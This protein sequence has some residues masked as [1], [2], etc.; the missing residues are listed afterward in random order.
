MSGSIVLLKLKN[1]L[2]FSQLRFNWFF[3]VYVFYFSQLN[4]S[5]IL[6][7]ALSC[8]HLNIIVF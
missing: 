8:Q 3:K 7:H 5:N 4:F 1:R 2:F 6:K